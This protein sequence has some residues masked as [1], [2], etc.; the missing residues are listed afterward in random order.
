MISEGHSLWNLVTCNFILEGYPLFFYD[1]PWNVAQDLDNQEILNSQVNRIE[2]K[3]VE[4]CYHEHV[5][6]ETE[7]EYFIYENR[8]KENVIVELELN[9]NIS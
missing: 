3:S 8:M 4:G 7:I 1:A 9:W 6:S 2:L 5:L